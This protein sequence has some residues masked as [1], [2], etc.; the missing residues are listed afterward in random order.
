MG[1]AP[2]TVFNYHTNICSVSPSKGNLSGCIALAMTQY[3]TSR[4]L[5]MGSNRLIRLPSNWEV[6]N[7]RAVIVNILHM[8]G[9]V[10]RRVSNI[11]G[12]IL[13]TIRHGD[14]RHIRLRN[15]VTIN[16][17]G[18]K[19]RPVSAVRGPS[20]VIYVPGH[21]IDRGIPV[22]C[23]NLLNRLGFFISSWY[24]NVN[25][26]GNRL[27]QIGIRNPFRVSII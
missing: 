21:H 27:V 22:D 3:P 11:N 19:V 13:L 10:I 1:H 23:C 7:N 18:L 20:R 9:L 12:L 14:C 2:L 24:R 8:H 25:C 17:R 6:S 15:C 26:P 16:R 4:N 5:G